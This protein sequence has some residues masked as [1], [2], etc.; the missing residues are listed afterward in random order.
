[1]QPKSA[2]MAR[3]LMNRYIKGNQQPFLAVLPQFEAKAILESDTSV[4]DPLTLLKTPSERIAS[5]HYTWLKSALEGF[6][7]EVRPLLVAPLSKRQSDQLTEALNITPLGHSLAPQ[8]KNYLNRILLSKVGGSNTVRAPEFLPQGPLSFLID[9]SLTEIVELCDFLG[10]Y[11]IGEELRHIVDKKVLKNVYQCLSPKEQAFLRQCMSTKIKLVAPG[12][13]LDR[14]K[15]EP[16]KL[17]H[18]MQARGL[19][20]LGKALSGSHE[21]LL[22]YLAHKLDKGRG[23]TLLRYYSKQPISGVTPLLIQ[24][25][26]NVMNILKKKE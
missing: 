12:L 2:L 19:L 23:E 6:S 22:W 7:E 16:T 4:N 8:V 15:G 13:G 21:D 3:L 26:Q 1:M 24:Q 11:D 17:R 10:L 18:A 9:C 14:W 20:R 5:L 25:V